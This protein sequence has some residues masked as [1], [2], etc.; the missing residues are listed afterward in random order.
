M[1]GLCAGGY[2]SSLGRSQCQERNVPSA[3][4]KWMWK[5][6]VEMGLKRPQTAEEGSFT[7]F[8]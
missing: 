5:E 8:S 6:M 4:G 7:A 1:T 3:M 2:A